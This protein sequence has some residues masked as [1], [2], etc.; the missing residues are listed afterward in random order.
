MIESIN[1]EDSYKN[2]IDVRDCINDENQKNYRFSNDQI[3]YHYC[4]NS[5][6]Y[7][8]YD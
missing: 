4:K 6:H 1:N 7:V 5:I 8:A 3:E 2:W